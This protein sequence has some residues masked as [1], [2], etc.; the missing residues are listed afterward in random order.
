MWIEDGPRKVQFSKSE[1]WTLTQKA[2][3]TH[4]PMTRY[5]RNRWDI[6]FLAARWDKEIAKL[7]T[8]VLS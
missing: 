1:I 5:E 7:I 2:R 6:L 8:P 3:V 4:E